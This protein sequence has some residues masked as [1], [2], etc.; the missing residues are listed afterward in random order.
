MAQIPVKEEGFNDYTFYRYDKI[1]TNLRQSNLEGLKKKKAF[2]STMDPRRVIEGVIEYENILLAR[3]K[4]HNSFRHS[5]TANVRIHH[6]R[7]VR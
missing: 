4:K 2:L 3:H 6:M 7:R 1:W 5:P